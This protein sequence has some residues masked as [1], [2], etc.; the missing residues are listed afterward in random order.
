MSFTESIQLML[1]LCMY[2]HVLFPECVPVLCY[3]CCVFYYRMCAMFL[4]PCVVHR[5]A[6]T[7]S[8]RTTT[9]PRVTSRPSPTTG[10]PAPVSAHTYSDHSVATS[11]TCLTRLHMVLSHVHLMLYRHCHMLTQCH[12]LSHV[13]IM[14]HCRMFIWCHKL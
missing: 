9:T 12:T 6:L 11:L 1:L 5:M 4:C 10:W 14:P 7:T 13:D 2:C 8:S 3:H